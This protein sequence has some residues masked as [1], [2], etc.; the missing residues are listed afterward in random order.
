VKHLAQGIDDVV[1]GK[2]GQ[3]LD[4]GAGRVVGYCP[5]RFLLRLVVG[6]EKVIRSWSTTAIDANAGLS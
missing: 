4:G 6:L 1:A 3:L 2:V 5:A